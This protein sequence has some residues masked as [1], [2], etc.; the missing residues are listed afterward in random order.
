MILKLF[1]S[2]QPISWL[3]F[4]AVVFTFRLI[5][6][7]FYAH[8]SLSPLAISDQWDLLAK[9]A[10][11]LPW[12]SHITGTIAIIIAAAIYNQVAHKIQIISDLN[13]YMAI[14]FAFVISLSPS[15]LW[16]NP[17]LISLPAL[18]SSISILG[19]QPKNTLHLK[20]TYNSSLLAGVAAVIYP[21]NGI[22]LIV[23]IIIITILFPAKW[24]HYALLII[25]FYTP[26]FFYE[27]INYLLDITPSV[28]PLLSTIGQNT[29]LGSNYM[30]L[31][32]TVG[33]SVIGLPTYFKGYAHKAVRARKLY[34]IHIIWLIIGIVGYFIF[35][36]YNQN[37]IGYLAFPLSVIWAA[38]QQVTRKWWISDL[39][40][41]ALIGA[42]VINHYHVWKQLIPS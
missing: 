28:A 31:F 42:I 23:S 34:N 7:L 4:T 18:I 30:I 6:F 14:L 39:F 13:T 20:S 5:A 25:G 22:F 27:S 19:N 16:L 33:L 29:S 3:I 9:V 17:F 41:L 37:I 24:R 11:N 15:N 12:L 8:L 21:P 38:G 26:P 36:N 40:I 1:K 35:N 2:S 10:I 32:S